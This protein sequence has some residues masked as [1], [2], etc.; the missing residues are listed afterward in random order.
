[1][2]MNRLL[3]VL[4]V[5]ILP[6][7]TH[8]QFSIQWQKCM[9]GTNDEIVKSI[10]QTSDSGFI[11][12]SSTLSNDGDVSGN[13]GNS[14]GW[15]IKLN[16]VGSIEW[17]KCLGGSGYEQTY[18]IQQTFDG[19]YIVAIIS[20]SNDGDVTNN[21]GYYDIWVVKLDSIGTIQWEKC[22]GGS[23]SED[24]YS[25]QQTSDGGYVIS[26]GTASNNADVS[27]NHGAYDAWVVKLDS[28]GAIQWQKCIG[29]SGNEL[30]YSIQQTFDG[31]YVLTGYTISND[32][33]LFGVSGFGI[34]W[35]AKLNDLGAIQW[36]RRLGGSISEYG[37]SIHQTYDAGYIV[38]GVTSSNEGDVTGNHG[39]DDA[40]VVK[41]D[42]SGAI[43]WQRCLGGSNNEQAYSIQQTLDSGFIVAGFT[44]SNDGDVS[45]N[46]GDIDAWV[47]KLNEV[48]VVQ[49][50]KCLGGSA[51]ETAYSIQQLSDG[52]FIVGGYTS[53]VDGDVIG[54]HGA[55]DS[56]I[57]KLNYNVGIEELS[58]LT[59]FT[60][61]PVPSN[62][63]LNIEYSFSEAADV[64]L[65]LRNILGE[66]LLQPVFLKNQ[67][68]LNVTKL[69]ISNL[70]DGIY[71]LNM[72][73]K[74][75]SIS[76]KVIVSH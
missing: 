16:S 1:M 40:W 50:Q 54:N 12:G 59:N 69:P 42:S 45:G 17:K 32:G 15:I 35:V 9:G 22:L 55:T 34:L 53:S 60:I 2:K 24:V 57:V 33:D 3:L 8:G 73:T 66:T 64:K 47:V 76:K 10:Q 72:T 36:Q 63:E 31:G 74:E 20:S 4:I 71:F 30:A 26:G 7:C 65:E 56:W 19:G 23:D 37:Y 46:F 67:M 41:L 52:S 38:A 28:I 75:G 14:D 25:I 29:G 5:L 13:H 44:T 62:D 21:H 6:F 61:Y 70:H 58:I 18:S 68:G 39:S 11:V 43:Q 27:G 49:G 51:G 48:G